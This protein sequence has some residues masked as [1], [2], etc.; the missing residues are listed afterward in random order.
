VEEKK[1]K[2]PRK[3]TIAMLFLKIGSEV[4]SEK[5]CLMNLVYSAIMGS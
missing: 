2:D 4:I 5:F 3:F 1:K